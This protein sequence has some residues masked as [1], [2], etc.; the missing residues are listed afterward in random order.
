MSGRWKFRAAL[1][2]PLVSLVLFSQGAEAQSTSVAGIWNLEMRNLMMRASGG[3]RNVLLRIEEGAGGLQ[4]QMT[5]PRNTF[6]DVETFRYEDGAMFVAFG[7]YDYSL[8]LEGGQ[9][10]GTMFS[11]VDTVSVV[12]TR[13]EGTMFVGDE[14]EIFHTTRTAVLG[15][16]TSLAPPADEPD[17]VG[18]VRSRIDSPDDLAWIVRGHAVFFTNTAEFEDD[19]MAYAGRSVTITGVWVGERIQIEEIMLADDAAR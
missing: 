12:G 10:I 6:L 17:P 16:R 18:W 4:A 5:S 19:L 14:P 7:A 9:L 2:L 15:H 11:P 13:Q 3:V 8:M 1:L